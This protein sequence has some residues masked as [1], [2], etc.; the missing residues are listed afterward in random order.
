M[1]VA[2]PPPHAQTPVSATSSIPPVN[3]AAVGVTD[4][5]FVKLLTAR[6]EEDRRV[7]LQ[8]KAEVCTSPNKGT[9]IQHHNLQHTGW[10]H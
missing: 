10:G 3:W 4:E 8:V 5:L 1:D 9:T 7:G 2:K 6:I